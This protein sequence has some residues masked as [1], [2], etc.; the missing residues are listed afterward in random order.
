MHGCQ[1]R[2]CSEAVG[3]LVVATGLF[4]TPARPEWAAPEALARTPFAGLV[5]DARD[6]TD[7]APAQVCGALRPRRTCVAACSMHV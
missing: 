2:A 4:N 5:V 7:T 1:L 3:F 6:F